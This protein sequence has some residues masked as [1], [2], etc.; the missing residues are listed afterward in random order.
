[1]K[2]VPATD[3]DGN[4]D[5][6]RLKR[7]WEHNG[8][9]KN[10]NNAA[11]PLEPQSSRRF[12]TLNLHWHTILPEHELFDLADFTHEER[13]LRITLRLATTLESPRVKMAVAAAHQSRSSK[14][15]TALAHP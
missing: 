14:S 1:M 3:G 4:N 11:K 8:E 15:T 5:E 13:D 10:G 2:E 6:P 12:Q 9:L 7:F